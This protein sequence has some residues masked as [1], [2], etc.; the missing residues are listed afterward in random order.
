AGGYLLMIERIA[1][2]LVILMLQAVCCLAQNSTITTYAG[3][4]GYGMRELLSAIGSKRD[5]RLATL[6]NR[7]TVGPK[8]MRS[9]RQPADFDETYKLITA[10]NPIL[11]Q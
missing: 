3:P 10:P 6:N 9:R 7:R 4:A 8:L 1:L 11:S 2:F 5:S